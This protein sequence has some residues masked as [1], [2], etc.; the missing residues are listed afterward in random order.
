MDFADSFTGDI[1]TTLS[2]VNGMAASTSTIVQ[3]LNSQRQSISSVSLDE[4]GINIVKYQQAY[5][6]SARVITAIDE[7]LD[8]LITSTGAST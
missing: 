3:N 1:A 5:D 2:N 4:E 8:T 6:A 7:M